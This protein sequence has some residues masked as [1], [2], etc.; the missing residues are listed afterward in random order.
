MI[1]NV[2]V[3]LNSFA[4]TV[5]H[6]IRGHPCYGPILV[7]VHRRYLLKSKLHMHVLKWNL[8]KV[9]LAVM[10]LFFTGSTVVLYYM[11]YRLLLYTISPFVVFWIMSHYCVGWVY[12]LL[13]MMMSLLLCFVCIMD[14]IINWLYI[15]VYTIFTPTSAPGTNTIVLK[16]CWR[17]FILFEQRPIIAG[18][19]WSHKRLH[20]RWW[21]KCL[22]PAFKV[23]K[24]IYND[25]SDAWSHRIC[26]QYGHAITSIWRQLWANLTK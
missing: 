8:R 23:A 9:V 4:T 26:T 17:I 5:K 22:I 18:E 24:M 3:H 21:Q 14:Y 1:Y 6:V 16:N 7:T 11:I 20:M 15:S 12:T 10:F 2:I 25:I 19:H 13:L